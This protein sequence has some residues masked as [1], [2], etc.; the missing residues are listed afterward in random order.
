MA[1][2]EL[3][4]RWEQIDYHLRCL[5]EL[6]LPEAEEDIE[7]FLDANEFGLALLYLAHSVESNK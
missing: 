3:Q 6:M 2:T 4:K 5:M 7:E 1:D